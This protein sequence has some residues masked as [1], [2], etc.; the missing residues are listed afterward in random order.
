MSTEQTPLKPEIEPL[1][2]L[3]VYNRRTQEWETARWVEPRRSEVD[4]YSDRREQVMR[5]HMI[6]GDSRVVRRHLSTPG[7]TTGGAS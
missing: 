3:E 5:G 7:R 2:G 4:A 6:Y 1:Y